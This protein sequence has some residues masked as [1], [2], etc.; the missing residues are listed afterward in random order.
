MHNAYSNNIIII[1]LL[2]LFQT[3][4]ILILIAPYSCDI[5]I[6]KFMLDTLPCYYLPIQ[7]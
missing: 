4:L 1:N 7:S 6:D 5:F 3:F 2:L